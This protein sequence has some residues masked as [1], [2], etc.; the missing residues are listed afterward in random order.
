MMRE[1]LETPAFARWLERLRDPVARE[2]ILVRIR[3][4]SLGLPGDVRAVGGRVSE[5]RIDYGPGYRVYFTTLGEYVILL[6]GGDKRTQ[7]RDINRAHDLVN[8]L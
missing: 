8:E 7:E 5:I 3:R 2:R 1:V 4:L 6:L